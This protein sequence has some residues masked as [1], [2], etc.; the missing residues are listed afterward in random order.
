M[1]LVILYLKKKIKYRHP[2][3]FV[4]FFWYFKSASHERNPIPDPTYCFKVYYYVYM[5][6]VII[7]L[8]KEPFFLNTNFLECMEVFSPTLL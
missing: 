2:Y 5:S 3:N 6:C 7:M 1:F 4:R 8:L